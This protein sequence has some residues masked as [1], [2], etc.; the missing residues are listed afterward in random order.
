[1]TKVPLI[2]IKNLT[3]E[4]DGDIVLKGIDLTFIRWNLN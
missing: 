1:M 2:E 4:F 3:K